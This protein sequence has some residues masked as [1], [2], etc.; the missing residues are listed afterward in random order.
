MNVFATDHPLASEPS[1]FARR[2]Q[3]R[4]LWV[5]T[6]YLLYALSLGRAN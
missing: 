6:G 3:R 4:L 2:L 1:A 5:A